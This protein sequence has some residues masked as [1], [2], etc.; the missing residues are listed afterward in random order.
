MSQTEA[1]CI[2]RHTFIKGELHLDGPTVIG[3]RVE[4]RI[5]AQDRLEIAVDGI[6]E[7]DIHGALIDIQGSVKGNVTA[8]RACRLGATARVTGELRAAN[9]AIAEG[10]SFVGQ[11]CVGAASESDED[12]ADRDEMQETLAADQAV[13]GAVNR[14]ESMATEVEQVAHIAASAASVPAPT[15]TIRVLPQVVQQTI[16]RSPK[17]IKAR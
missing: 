12:E 15:P 14:I 11:V 9:L 13:A 6:V 7:G 10:A 3:G 16:N 2:A 1:T 8:D 4:G 5:I 17:I